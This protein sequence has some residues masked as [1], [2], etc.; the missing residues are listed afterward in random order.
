MRKATLKVSVNNKKEF[1]KEFYRTVADKTQKYVDERMRKFVSTD[2][3][4]SVL[5]E[6]IVELVALEQ[7]GGK[8]YGRLVEDTKKNR[9]MG[10]VSVSGGKKLRMRSGRSQKSDPNS[11]EEGKTI[12]NLRKNMKIMMQAGSSSPDKN[13]LVLTVT[14]QFDNARR[15]MEHNE[16]S[17]GFSAMSDEE[18]LRWIRNKGLKYASETDSMGSTVQKLATPKQIRGAIL[19]HGAQYSSADVFRV[20]SSGKYYKEKGKRP[21]LSEFANEVLESEYFLEK[22]AEQLEAFMK[23]RLRG[24][25]ARRRNDLGNKKK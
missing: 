16:E 8:A 6:V 23:H 22:L 2:A 19:A 14:Q 4:L 1:E 24:R 10:F 18:Q 20:S 7:Y 11:E 3:I 12:K 25:A 5:Q 21:L 17:P 13:Q 15:W 9:A